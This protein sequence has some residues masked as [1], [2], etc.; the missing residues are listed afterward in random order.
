M[1]VREALAQARPMLEPLTESPASDARLLLADTLGASTT[2]ILAHEDATI[3][4]DSADRFSARVRRCV[5]GEPLPYVLGWWEFYGRPFAV[6]PRVLIPRPETEVL[7]DHALHELGRRPAPARV[8][9]IGT[10][11]GCIA[12]T[13]AAEVPGATIFAA[14]VSREAI[15]VARANAE[16]HGVGGQMRF[17]QASLSDGLLGGWNLICANLPYLRS[18]RWH[19]ATGAEGEPRLALDGGRN[20]TT[21]TERLI[22]SLRWALAPRGLALIEIDEDQGQSLSGIA[23]KSLV[24]GAI[25]IVADLAGKPRLLKTRRTS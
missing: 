21:L 23:A 11:S 7:V 17:I 5:A 24:D 4:A 20:G 8:I 25:E 3:S 15:R 10:G 9:D 19:T 14:D 6:D 13:L 1:R 16:R 2:W 22:R 12:V 18:D